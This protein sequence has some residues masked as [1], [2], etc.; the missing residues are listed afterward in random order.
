MNYKTFIYLTL[1]LSAVAVML[2]AG[3]GELLAQIPPPELP[4]APD[5]SPVSCGP[6]LLFAALVFGIWSVRKRNGHA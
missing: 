6:L 4:G 1:T 5:Q 2:T 3:A